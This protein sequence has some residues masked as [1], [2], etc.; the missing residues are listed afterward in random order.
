[1]IMLKKILGY[2][3]IILSSLFGFVTLTVFCTNVIPEVKD[4]FSEST[5][6]GSGFAIG[7]FIG[8]AFLS[9]MLYAL[10]RLGLK[11]VKQTAKAKS[12]QLT[13]S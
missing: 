12:S 2:V 1:M 4:S 6:Y 9:S 3:L 8:F 13:E 10:Y 5:A 7:Y 11:L